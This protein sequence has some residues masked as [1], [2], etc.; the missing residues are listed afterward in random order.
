MT[1]SRSRSFVCRRLGVMV[2]AAVTTW[3]SAS[4]VLAQTCADVPPNLGIRDCNGNGVEDATDIQYGTSQ[5]ADGDSIPDGCDFQICRYLWEGFQ[6]NPPF[7]PFEGVHGIDYDGDGVAWDNPSGSVDV[8]IVGFPG[9]SPAE[10]PYGNH[11]QE[12]NSYN[13]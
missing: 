13:S 5:D 7:Y 10:Q 8:K 3:L 4:A 2:T 6:A 1:S 12:I 9:L 11:T